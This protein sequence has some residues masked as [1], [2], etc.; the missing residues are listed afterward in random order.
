MKDLETLIKRE[1]LKLKKDLIFEI[2]T[3]EI[4]ARFM[5]KTL[6]QLKSVTENVFKENRI[7]SKE[8]KTYGTPRRLTIF[9]KGVKEKQEDLETVIKGPSFKAAYDSDGNPTKAL[10]GFLKG[11]GLKQENIFTKELSGTVYVYAKKFEEGENTAEVLK[12]ILPEVITAIN[13]PKSMKWGNK[14]FKFVRPI[15]WLMP[16]YGD[17]LIQFDKDGIPCNRITKGHRTL[18]TGDIEINNTDEYFDKLR[19]GYV[20]VDQNERR[21]IIK[22]QIEEIMKDKNGTIVHDD[23]LLEEILYLVEYP[24]AFCGNFDKEFLTLPKE[25]VITPMKEH[26]RYFPIEDKNGNLLNYFIAV[27]NGSR[28]YLEVVKEGNEKV[29]RARL[30]DARFFFDEDKKI[31]LEQS[32]ERLKN[33]VFQETIGT[34]FEKTENI[35]KIAK[36]L[37]EELKLPEEDKS[38][39]NR[40]AYLCKADLVTNMVKEFSELQGIMGKEYALIQNER[41][42]VANAIKE[43]YMPR[44]A[45]DEIPK[46][47]IGSILSI[48]DKLDTITGCFSIGIQPTGS[49]DPYALRRSA[50]GIINIILEK[51]L[52]LDLKELLHKAIE[53]FEKKGILKEVKDKTV[54]DIIRFFKE[55]LRNVLLDRGYDYDILDSVLT[56]KTNNIY[57]A[58]L[59]IDELSKWKNKEVGFLD[60]ISSFN[61]VTN[62]ASKCETPIININ[63]INEDEEKALYSAYKLTETEFTAAVNAKNYSEALNA[64]KHLK[65]PIDNFFDNIMVMVEEDDLRNNRLAILKL[66]SDMMN[67]FA[68]FGAIVINR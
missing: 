19:E 35:K 50:I 22:E 11:N 44:Y 33:V 49:Q 62:L 24:T 5:N 23:D 36:Y 21:K 16:I 61:R 34:M 2:G 26:Q 6:D 27:R 25:V 52:N 43:H 31:K 67:I 3:E 28:E 59:K 7:I 14:S 9:V 17:F 56:V 64:L 40:A 32:V 38:Y 30:S 66:I 46:S 45:G 10:S 42:G 53:P 15:R 41:L 18:C 37:S 29:L 63:M 51:S 8:M 54:N 60:I 55:R 20:I 4:P 1:V 39:L 58:Y 47:V 57:D 65:V 13:F 68:D 48:S 12:R